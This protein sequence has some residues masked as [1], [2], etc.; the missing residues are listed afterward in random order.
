MTMKLTLYRHTKS[1]SSI[2]NSSPTAP[3][4][5]NSPRADALACV[6]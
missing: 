4:A 2:G 3:T 6:G 1:T 5:V